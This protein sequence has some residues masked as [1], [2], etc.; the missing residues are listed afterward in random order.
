M[1]TQQVLN[2]MKQVLLEQNESLTPEDLRE[3][4]SL[5]NELGLDSLRLEAFF[6][7]LKKHL[8][9]LELGHWLVQAVRTNQDTL[10]NL[11]RFLAEQQLQKGSP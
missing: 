1:D 10:Q 3:D 2:L 8:P 6:A 4:I 9:G 5:I 11:S 7:T